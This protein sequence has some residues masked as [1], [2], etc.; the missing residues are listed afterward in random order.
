MKD[1]MAYRW[2]RHFG[3]DKVN[4]DFA[5]FAIAFNRKKICTKVVKGISKSFNNTKSGLNTAYYENMS[6]QHRLKK[7]SI[8]NERFETILKE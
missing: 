5:F 3:L 8:K 1:N 2:F 7:Q 4:K 6:Y